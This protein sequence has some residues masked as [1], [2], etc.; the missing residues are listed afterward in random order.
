VIQIFDI[1]RGD[2]SVNYAKMLYGI[3]SRGKY[4]NT[5]TAVIDEKARVRFPRKP[6]GTPR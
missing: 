2:I 4:V 1:I 5:F 3:W 6:L